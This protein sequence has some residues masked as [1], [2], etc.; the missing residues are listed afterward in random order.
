MKFSV[1][2]I[3]L[4]AFTRL[5]FTVRTKWCIC[6]QSV[7]KIEGV[8][9]CEL[10]VTFLIPYFVYMH[11]CSNHLY[12]T[13]KHICGH[14]ES[15]FQ[16]FD[17]LLFV[18]MYY[19]SSQSKIAWNTWPKMS[20]SHVQITHLCTN[21]CTCLCTFFL[22]YGWLLPVADHLDAW[23]IIYNNSVYFDSLSRYFDTWHD[24]SWYS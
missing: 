9:N 24:I 14:V 21:L 8:W 1:I 20:S 6:M 12:G 22:H 11:I 5:N 18:K 23:Q 15:T 19:N 17:V 3:G 10:N 16:Y 4:L 2:Q 7:K 13:S